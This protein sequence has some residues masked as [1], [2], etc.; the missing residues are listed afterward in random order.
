MNLKI[1]WQGESSKSSKEVIQAGLQQVGKAEDLKGKVEVSVNIV[2]EKEIAKLNQ[3]Y[4][5]KIGPTDVLS[6]PLEKEIGPDGVMRLGDIVLN[7]KFKNKFEF[8]AKH[9]MLHLLGKH[10]D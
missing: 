4:M 5:G 1:V 7:I 10:H 9:G 8:L 2:K 6:F 3:Q